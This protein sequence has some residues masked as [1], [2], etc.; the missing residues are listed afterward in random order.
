MSNMLQDIATLRKQQLVDAASVKLLS[1][2]LHECQ[3]QSQKAV[4]IMQARS[5][6][7]AVD[8][9]T[10]FDTPGVLVSDNL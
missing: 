9:R 5:R 4:S 3:L 6:S 10:K 1:R 8:S 2:R 7:N